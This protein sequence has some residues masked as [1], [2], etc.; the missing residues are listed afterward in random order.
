MN[1]A[2]IV[3]FLILIFFFFRSF[4]TYVYIILY[5][6]GTITYSYCNLI[7]GRFHWVQFVVTWNPPILLVGLVSERS[8]ER[9]DFT[10]MFIV[11]LQTT[12]RVVEML[13]SSLV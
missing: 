13:Q 5:F 1:E 4:I 2:F 8:E 10:T 12:F 11:F 3:I 6:I 7:F 9:I